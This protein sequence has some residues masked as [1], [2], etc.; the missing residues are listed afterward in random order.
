MKYLGDNIYYFKT[1]QEFED[2]I[3]TGGYK[4]AILVGEIIHRNKGGVWAKI[5]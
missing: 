3:F 4:K 5:I 2:Y 1:E